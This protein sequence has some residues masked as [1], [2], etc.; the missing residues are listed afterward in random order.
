M[1]SS[2]LINHK[3]AR[4]VTLNELALIESPPPTTSWFPTSHFDVFRAVDKTLRSAGYE[5]RKQS[6]SITPDKHRFFG[7]LDLVSRITDGITLAVGVR[8]STDKSFP[9]GMAV[10]SRVMV[11]DNL[12][13]H[14]EIVI[15][16]KHTRFGQERYVEGISKAVASLGQ[17]QQAQAVWIDRLRSWHLSR[18]EADSIILQSFE[19]DLI[20]TRQLPLLIEEWRKP[21]HEDFKD[22][23]AW[24]LWNAYTAVLGKTTQS[25][26]PAKAATTTIRLQGLF[27]PKDVIETTCE[28]IAV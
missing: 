5:V 25:T 28:R 26:A 18:E 6:F 1:A 19:T 16:K 7:T 9:I 22:G 10:G 23:S 4:E 2:T 12:S 3:G 8:N 15:A 14:G 24:S 20:G 21:E 27:K 11:C 17:Y 13:F